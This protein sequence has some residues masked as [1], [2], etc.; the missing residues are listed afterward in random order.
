MCL[1]DAIGRPSP[2]VCS[3]A[4]GLARASDSFCT[5]CSGH[6]QVA[7]G[8]D[9]QAG[10][11]Q[12]AKSTVLKPAAS[13]NE[14]CGSRQ[15][16]SRR[17]NDSLLGPHLTTALI[18]QATDSFLDYLQ[19]EGYFLRTRTSGAFT[20]KHDANSSHRDSRPLVSWPGRQHLRSHDSFAAAQSHGRPYSP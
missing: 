4:A 8:V 16:G 2:A 6:L 14:A 3:V 9:W 5:N 17:R 11:R 20:A 18:K 13:Q 7:E 10:I 19:S 1:F 15:P 12:R